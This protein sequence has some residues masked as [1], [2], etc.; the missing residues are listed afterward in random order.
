MGSGKNKRIVLYDNMLDQLTH[1]EIIAV[2]AHELGHYKM[3]RK[4]IAEQ[5]VC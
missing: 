3:N 5:E 1:Q 4:Y 2:L